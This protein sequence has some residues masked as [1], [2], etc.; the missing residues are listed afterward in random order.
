MKM[1]SWL[2][3]S[4]GALALAA[5]VVFAFSALAATARAQVA[6]R[7]PH[8]LSDVE[9]RERIPVVGSYLSDLEKPSR[10]HYATWIAL[11]STAAATQFTLAAL[12]NSPREATNYTVGGLLSVG[13]VVSVLFS[14]H[15]ARKAH[16]RFRALPE[17]TPA[18]RRNKLVQG[19][20]WLAEEAKDER[21]ARSWFP[22][23]GA[24]VVGLGVG[25]ALGFAY[26]DNWLAG[27][28]V[29]LGAAVVTEIR[30]WS[31]PRR[32]MRYEQIYRL[33]PTSRTVRL[34]PRVGPQMVGLGVSGV[35]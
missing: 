32:A 11:L 1:K 13:G 22:Q 2:R 29:G 14:P 35:F 6:H 26:E 30:V 9:V 18:E 21:F 28:R 4:T 7:P 31:R 12:A 3:G 8:E 24:L 23:V 10:R 25:L 16:R 27:L 17:G 34:T 33:D 20:T 5:L 15:P 19:E